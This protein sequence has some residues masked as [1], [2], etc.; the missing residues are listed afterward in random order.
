MPN[1]PSGSNRNRRRRR[2]GRR[3]RIKILFTG[4]IMTVFAMT[5]SVGFPVWKYGY[6]SNISLPLRHERFQDT[7]L[8]QIRLNGHTSLTL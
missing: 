8:S 4:G 7:P 3:R 6:P 2:R 5:C 1:A